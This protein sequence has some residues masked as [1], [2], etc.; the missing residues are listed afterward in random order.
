MIADLWQDLRYGARM[1]WK[2][3]G[4]TLIAVF[5]LALGIG[6]NTAIFTVINGVLLRPLPYD[7]PERLV[8][9]WE[10]NPRRN[11]EQQLVAPP[12]LAEWREQSRSF[13]NIAYWT[14]TGEFNLVTA[15]GSEKAKCAYVTSNLFA[16]LRVRP[17]LGRVFMPEE[18]Q[19][20]GNRA[21]LLSYDYWQRRFAA[22]PQV[23][24]RTLTVDTFGRRDYTIVG[25]MQPGFRFPNQT[26]IWLP[27]GW[28]GIPR[29]RRG[30]WL[31]VI[32]RLKA[33][34]P[35]A[36][37]QAEMN[38]I[39]ARIAGQ[40]PEELLSSQVAII[41]LLEQTL[42]RNLRL[43]LL[44]L[45]GV[46]ACVL[47][48]ACANVA[49]LLLAR[50]ADRQKE[51]AIRLALGG[52]RW[53]MI[54]QLLTES[55]LLALIGG[56][57]GVLLASWSLKLLIAFNA[58][59]VP[60]LSETRLDGWSLAF[61]L[62][63]AG[64]TGLI[65][66]LAP[67]WQTTK[68][69]LNIALKDTGKGAASGL[70]RSRL[71]SL[72]VIAEV[73]MSMVLLIGAGL[74]IRSFAQMTRVDR[75]FQP[76]RLLMAKLDFSVSGFTT[77]VRPTETRPQT[78]IRELM[79]RLKNQPGVQVVAA[80]GDKASFQITLEGRQTGVEEDHPRTG[81]QGVSGDYF[82]AMGIP[83]LQGRAFTERDTLETPRVAVL[84]A[85]LAKRCF[86]N[87]DPIGKRI[88]PGR[89]N[90]GQVGQIDRYTN[91]PMWTEIVGV[92]ADVKSLSLDPKVESNVYVPYWQWPMQTPT[93][94]VRTAGNPANLAAA[95]YSEVK[96]LNKSLPMPKVQTMNEQLS[97]VV[98]QPRFQ[99]LLL[100]LF[101]L[102]T[103]VLVSAGLYGVVSY[104]VAQ[105]THEIGV[106]MALGAQPQDVLK[107]V[108]GQGMKLALIGIALG[109]AGAL[110]L[111]RL[112]KTLLFGVTAT[113]PLAFVLAALLLAGVV[114]LAC[115]LPARRAA[116]VD[117]MIALRYE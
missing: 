53:R 92:V 37:A 62:L 58:D 103:L 22:D 57:A 66:G 71:R 106:R 113:D 80:A 86:P 109:L 25:V 42:G 77:W 3:P 79:E 29:V 95:I 55:M 7:E 105:R 110:M 48:I 107:L 116:Q 38:M 97:D 43:A 36:G 99:T 101:G 82:R 47:L 98:A 15:D 60:R 64:L 73:A 26:E 49:N 52:S 18:D 90:P 94:F 30:P 4:F 96:A 81:F 16:T 78:T 14:G 111:T 108:I 35:L 87:E 69:D 88:Y 19:H 21:A 34:V 45:W 65:F 5:T 59:H 75:G 9:L 63:V 83:M 70:Q 104:S 67:A 46:V 13:E 2:K 54:R 33:G 31:S 74:M 24:G 20:E 17:Q 27:V 89:L 32:A 28:D 41:P 44:I 61:T 85:S 23:I 39:Q 72:L 91:V 8:M 102:V 100:G 40:H 76:E 115:Y 114:L 84:S 12:H 6:A 51:I 10:S 11:V 117:P 68:P 56:V 1:L 112:L 50:A 93:L